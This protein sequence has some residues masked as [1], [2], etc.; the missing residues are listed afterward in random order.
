MVLG[1]HSPTLNFIPFR[2]SKNYSLQAIY[3]TNVAGTFC[4]GVVQEETTIFNG[5]FP[6]SECSL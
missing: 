1:I 6:L 5:F 4:Y 2:A 3:S